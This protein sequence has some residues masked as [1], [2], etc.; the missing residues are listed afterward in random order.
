M[1]AKATIS[2][3][4]LLTATGKSWQQWSDVL[5]KAPIDAALFLRQNYKLDFWWSQAIAATFRQP[6]RHAVR[7]N[8]DSSLVKLFKAC[9]PVFL[10]SPSKTD[11]QQV[12]QLSPRQKLE[13]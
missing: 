3:A 9:H 4:Q 12:P 8:S 2:D 5:E 7:R 10:V 6:A 11:R 1:R 13:D